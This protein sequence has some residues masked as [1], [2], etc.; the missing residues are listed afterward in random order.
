VRLV[1]ADTGPLNYLILIRHIDLLPVLFEK[2]VLP[3]AVQ[4]ELASGQAPLLVRDWIANLPNWAQVR[5]APLS[6][7]EDASLKGI[8]A[9]ERAAIQLAALLNADLLLMDDRKGVTGGSGKRP[10]SDRY[11]GHSRSG[12]ATRPGGLRASGRAASADQFQISGSFTGCAAEETQRG[13]W[14]HLRLPLSRC[15]REYPLWHEA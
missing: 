8:D 5:E 3:A 6:Q 11:A 2:V 10:L 9:G 14:T 7:A 1:I 13:T 4:V 15:A 12:S